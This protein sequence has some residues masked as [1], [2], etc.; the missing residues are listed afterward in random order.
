MRE[1]ITIGLQEKIK[2]LKNRIFIGDGVENLFLFCKPSF[3]SFRNIILI[4][5]SGDSLAIGSW[6]IPFSGENSS[7]ATVS[8]YVACDGVHQRAVTHSDARNPLTAVPLQWTPP[9][10]FHGTVII[11]ATIVSNYTHYWT[12]LQ[13]LPVSV[14]YRVSI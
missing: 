13:S 9:H 6:Y 10:T 12:N 11:T 4:A 5:V 1:M 7:L 8:S 3:Q 2:V 14:R